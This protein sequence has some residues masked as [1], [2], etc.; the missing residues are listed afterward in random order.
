M[1]AFAV[2]WAEHQPL[3]DALQ[4]ASA[5]AAIKVTR[6]GTT[7]A[8]PTREEIELFLQEQVLKNNAY[9]NWASNKIFILY[10]YII[11]I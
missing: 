4:F 3:S 1:G 5:G 6:K 8:N 7:M 11:L 10:I 2:A 9:S